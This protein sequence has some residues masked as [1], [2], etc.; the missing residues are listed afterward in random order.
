MPDVAVVRANEP[1]IADQNVELNRASALRLIHQLI[2]LTDVT[3]RHHTE[4]LSIGLWKWTEAEG[5]AP[6]AKYNTRYV[7]AGVKDPAGPI[8]V[9]HEHVWTRKDLTTQLLGQTWDIDA[10]EALLVERGVACIVTVEEHGRLSGQTEKGWQRYTAAGIAVW[11]RMTGTWMETPPV[12]S[13]ATAPRP[14]SIAELASSE[15]RTPA[16]AEAVT[17]FAEVAGW[18]LAVAVRANT[19]A[20]SHKYYRV[21]DTLIEEPTRAAAYVHWTGK[22]DFALQA[23]MVS[24]TLLQNPLVGTLADATYGITTNL[25]TAEGFEVA[26]E[27]LAVALEQI[28]RDIA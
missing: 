16:L 1:Y 20:A 9:N 5:V 21:H 17:R 23:S 11:D 19:P 6:N 10:L 15:C 18:Q 25:A 7:S 24:P 14:L 3:T 12:T 28:R 8:G 13:G 26:C 22:V 27:L 4:Q 2:Q